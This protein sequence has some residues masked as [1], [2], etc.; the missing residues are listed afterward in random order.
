MWFFE[1]MKPVVA[2]ED[3]AATVQFGAE[4][5]RLR[6]M[7]GLSQRGLGK[8]VGISGQQVG[9][10]ERATRNPSRELA[11]SADRVLGANGSLLALWPRARRTPHR[12]LE[13][14]V[15]LE[16]K[17]HSIRVFH[18]QIVPGLLQTADYAGQIL[19]ATW[20]PHTEAQIDAHVETRMRRQEIFER[21]VPPMVSVVLDEAALMRGAGDSAVMK[22]QV[23]R[24]ML[25]AQRPFVSI[26][27]LPM[28]AGPHAATEGSFIV[29][30]L[31]Q[32]ESVVY[33]EPV[34][35]GQLLTDVEIVGNS[36]RRFGSLQGQAMSPAESLVYLES[37]HGGGRDGP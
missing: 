35:P 13:D 20:P 18:C 15:E 28:S 36:G 26:Q 6:E 21:A 8:A 30:D 34:G 33:V 25:M 37:L 2:P 29:L 4:L 16:A 1:A 7:A 14:Y 10:V 32:T 9:A 17:A 27:V 3:Q 23:E 5:Q 12:W 24:L 22:Q 11:E 19:R 31:T